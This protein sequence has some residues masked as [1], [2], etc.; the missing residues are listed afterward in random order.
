MLGNPRLTTLNLE[1]GEKARRTVP[2]MASWA[3]P[4]ANTTCGQCK[5][6]SGDTKSNARRC[7]KYTAMMN[8]ARGPRVPRGTRSC[9]FFAAAR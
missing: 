7:A 5:F 6:W 2:G 8:N 9:K 3:E 1:L 4:T